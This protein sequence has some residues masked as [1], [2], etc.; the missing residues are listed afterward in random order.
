[1]AAFADYKKK[2]D[3]LV[4]VPG[5]LA[6][7]AAEYGTTIPTKLTDV[8][9]NLVAL[10]TGFK[11]VGEVAKSEGLTVTPELS[12]AD[13]EGYG[14]PNPRRVV[15]TK[16]TITVGFTAQESRALNV[17]MFW[18][19]EFGSVTADVNG[20]WQMVKSAND[21]LL[22]RYYSLIIIGQDANEVGNIFPYY[23]FPKVSVSKTEAQKWDSEKELAYPFE[24][25]AYEGDFG[26][27]SATIVVGAGGAGQDSIN[28]AAG[29][30][31]GT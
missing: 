16:E 18:N 20:E 3:A 12:T 9:G 13:I 21:G 14:S 28:V 29:F 7:I 23:I 17:E 5:N 11:A 4:I 26:L 2:D 25:S 10:P 24:F 8:S 15:R 6:V 31:P 22:N 27:G 1:M 30:V 19:Q